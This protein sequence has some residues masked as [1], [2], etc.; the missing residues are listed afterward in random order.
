MASLAL[1]RH[2]PRPIPCHLGATAVVISVAHERLLVLPWLG[3]GK[4][5]AMGLSS[6]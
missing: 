1:L 6:L 4:N 2:T 3:Y 5:D